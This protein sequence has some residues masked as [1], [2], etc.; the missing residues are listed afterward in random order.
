MRQAGL[1]TLDFFTSP[2]QPNPSWLGTLKVLISI[3]SAGI[4][5]QFVGTT[6]LSPANKKAFAPVTFTLAAPTVTALNASPSDVSL[7]IELNVNAG[8]GP[9]FVD[10]VRFTN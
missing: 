3:P 1:L 10:N 4:H 8:S 9:Y 5:D 7:T 2:V 6:N